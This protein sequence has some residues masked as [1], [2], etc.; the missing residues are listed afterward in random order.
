MEVSGHLVGSTAFKAA[1]TGD[2]RLAGSI[3]VHLRQQ[4]AGQGLFRSTKS[5]QWSQNGHS[6]ETSAA[7]ER[8]SEFDLSLHFRLISLFVERSSIGSGSATASSG[9]RI[10]DLFTP[11]VE[12]GPQEVEGRV[13]HFERA[14]R[15]IVEHTERIV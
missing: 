1:E 6:R 2:P 8:V 14:A 9:E 4:H 3:P 7:D 5:S 10:A 13:V 12:L 15:Q 11:V